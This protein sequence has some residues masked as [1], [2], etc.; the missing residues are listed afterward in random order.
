LRKGVP[1]VNRRG[2][3]VVCFLL[4]TFLRCSLFRVSDH[5]AL[6]RFV[7]IDL[8]HV[9]HRVLHTENCG[10]R[11]ILHLDGKQWMRWMKVSN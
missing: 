11:I 8:G 2:D 5:F 9:V 7:Q 1:V 6:F 3:I 10:F 4:R